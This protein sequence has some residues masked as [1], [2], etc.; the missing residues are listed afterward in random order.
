MQLILVGFA[1]LFLVTAG[2]FEDAEAQLDVKKHPAGSVIFPELRF[3]FDN[4]NTAVLILAISIP[5][6]ATLASY[7]LDR[8]P[9]KF[10]HPLTFLL[11]FETSKKV[12]IIA[13][14]AILSVYVVF[15]YP[16]LSREEYG[17][18]GDYDAAK[19]LV[20]NFE[21]DLPN[22]ITSLRIFKVSL[23]WFSLEFLGNIRLVP[24]FISISTLFVT[25]LFT[26]ELTNKRFSGLIAMVAVAQSSI[27]LTYDTTATYDNGW[28]L[29]YLLSLFFVL[30]KWYLSPALFLLA[31]ISKPLVAVFILP[32]MFFI[33][34]STLGR[35]QKRTLLITYAAMLS[36]A[37][38]YILLDSTPV[39][40]LEFNAA[41][42]IEFTRALAIYMSSELLFLTS[43]MP[44]IIGLYLVGK[45]R[46][47]HAL[48]VLMLM[49]GVLL[50][51]YFLDGFTDVSSQRY[52]MTALL[53]FFSVGLGMVLSNN[54][55]SKSMQWV[56]EIILAISLITFL[57]L[58]A[59]TLFP[60]EMNGILNALTRMVA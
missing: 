3:P 28:I 43:F 42:F 56:P 29:F 6:L 44:V 18:A 41:E 23:L 58:L 49:T 5:I 40:S 53:V 30:K 10:T 32:M 16:E 60:V 54:K 17:E 12:T 46:N 31:L 55:S 7:Q 52:R 21:N 19:E 24:F 48:S 39:I 4:N 35:R 50:G 37:A 2:F 13:L 25:Y 59:Y 14:V 22:L 27:F 33:F 20:E 8:M 26:K 36:L 38:V 45:K 34:V 57:P 9:K 47:I 15:A 11:R 1:V 51:Y